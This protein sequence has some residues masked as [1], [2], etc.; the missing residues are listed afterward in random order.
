VGSSP[1]R[2]GHSRNCARS[3]ISPTLSGAVV[4]LRLITA[5]G[6]AGTQG[7][8]VQHA[9]KCATGRARGRAKA[10]KRLPLEVQEQLLDAIYAGQPFRQVLRDLCLTSNQVWGLTRAGPEWSAAL[11]AAL[12]TARRD[13]LQHGTTAAYVQG[14]VCKECRDDDDRR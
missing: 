5:P 8:A 1:S 4:V 3:A 13:D 14:F 2:R 6:P 9:G 10:K 7:P 11:E 12:T